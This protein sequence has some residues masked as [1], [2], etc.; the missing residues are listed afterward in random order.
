MFTLKAEKRR[1][2]ALEALYINGYA[3]RGVFLEALPIPWRP[4]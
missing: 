2:R 3:R 4:F 1:Q